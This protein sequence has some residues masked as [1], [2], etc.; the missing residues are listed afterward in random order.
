MSTIGPFTNVPD[1]GSPL[2]SAWAQQLTAYAVALPKGMIGF[3]LGPAADTGFVYGSAP[4]ELA[5]LAVNFDQVAGRW[6]RV[7]TL[8]QVSKDA[9]PALAFCN[10]VDQAAALAHQSATTMVANAYAAIS[11]E[12]T[13]KAATTA[14]GRQFKTQIACTAGNLAYVG[15]GGYRSWISLEDLGTVAP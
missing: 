14:A 1:P 2:Q 3:N 7:R 6:Y 15:S 12:H 13:F 4:S 9:T 8:V 11:T 10:L 5:G